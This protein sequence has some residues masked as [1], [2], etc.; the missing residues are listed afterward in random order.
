[1]GPCNPV[2]YTQVIMSVLALVC[3]VEDIVTPQQNIVILDVQILGLL[4]SFVIRFDNIFAILDNNHNYIDT[5]G[6]DLSF[7]PVM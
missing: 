7:V 6:T 3:L 4:I 5:Q 2:A 1:M